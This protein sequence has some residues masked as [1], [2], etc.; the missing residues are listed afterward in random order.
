MASPVTTR[1]GPLPVLPRFFREVL[2]ALGLWWAVMLGLY[3]GLEEYFLV[4]ALVGTPTL[5]MLW[6]VGRSLG[7]RYLTYRPL[8]W[9]IAIVTMWMIPVTGLVFTETNWSFSVKSAIFFALP[10]VI[11]FGGILVAL[12]WAQARPPV[13]MFFRPDLLFGDG[14]T[15][16]GGTLMLLLGMR[17]LFAGHPADM[18]WALPRWDWH[19]LAFG[20]A[21][22]I[23]PIVLMRGMMK[24]VQRLMRLRDGLFTGYPS[25]A[26]REW[27]LLF[28][29]LNFGFAFH[30]VF[31]GRTVFSTL[32]EPGAY[33]IT[34]QFWIGIG[35]MGAA[36]WWLLFVKGGI[37]KL[38]GEPFFFETFEQ[39]LQ[40]QM[41]FT[42]AWGLFFYGFMSVLNSEAFGG[43]QPW[44]TQSGVG[45]GFLVTGILMLT[46]G[47]AIAQHY[48]RQGMLAHFV[49]AILPTQVD[50]ARERMMARI[51]KDLAQLHPKQQAAVWMTMHR[52]W[53]GID[54]D[55]RSL[56]AWTT[57]NALAQ[58]QSGRREILV[59]LQSDALAHLAEP[60]RV[61]AV[62]EITRAISRL[63]S[64]KEVMLQG[65]A[66]TFA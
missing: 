39:T 31:T 21:L 54:K 29:G 53:D 51:L 61:R 60:E 9:V 10:P 49:G 18:S 19:S 63:E 25:I 5:V 34:P 2:P 45:I 42:A 62:A 55:E 57:V 27:L 50:R 59:R 11:A 46:F 13:R 43:I 16:V 52:A 8:P 14:R 56:M 1:Q 12:P 6:P 48:Q 64:R 33:P 32:G 66:Q 23:I 17:Y 37:K 36:A 4:I 20:I 35:L 58:M 28:F 7:R 41:V 3:F 30:H 15:L 22:G 44:D 47:R 38:I 26:F 65:Y 40:K 24:L